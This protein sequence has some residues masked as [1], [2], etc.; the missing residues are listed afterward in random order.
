MKN[1]QKY[2][3]SELINKLKDLNSK[4]TNSQKSFSGSINNYFYEII[5]LFITFKNL[6]L[7]LTLVSLIIGIFRKFKI[8]RRL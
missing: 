1:L 6:L 5:N 4:N 7:K 3:K 8:F 2:N